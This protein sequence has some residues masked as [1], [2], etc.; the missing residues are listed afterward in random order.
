[1]KT[2]NLKE[3][4]ESKVL[5]ELKKELGR[6]NHMDIPHIEKVVVHVGVGKIHK[7]TAEIE[8]IIEDLRVMTGQKPQVIV[9]KKAIAGFKVR[10]GATSGIKVTLR[11][12]R[13]WDFLD[14]LVHVTLPRTRDFQGIGVKAVDTN[15]N[16]NI[17]IREHTIFPEIKPERVSRVFGLEVTVVSSAKNQEEG[18]A[19]FKGL[20]FPLQSNK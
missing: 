20:G 4:Y 14:R 3:V 2:V 11:K 12:R 13:M 17:G 6:E 1:M 10:Q 5:P 18:Y 7:E 16:L 19:L 9:A 8:K 15:G